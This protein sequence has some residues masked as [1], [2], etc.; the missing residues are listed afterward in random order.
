MNLGLGS[1]DRLLRD[2]FADEEFSFDQAEE[3]LG[4]PA[5]QQRNPHTT[6]LVPRPRSLAA[7]I[8]LEKLQRGPNSPPMLVGIVLTF[9]QSVRIDFRILREALGEAVAGPVIYPG[10][11]GT[12]EFAFHNDTFECSIALDVPQRSMARDVKMVERM[13]LR[14]IPLGAFAGGN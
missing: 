7:D 13:I 9:S 12:L 8:E 2:F 4:A 3:L 6:R 5:P 11:P 14:R 1:F 10:G